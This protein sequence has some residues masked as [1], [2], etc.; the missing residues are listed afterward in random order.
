M[1]PD[2]ARPGRGSQLHAGL[3]R[4]LSV[5]MILIGVALV[6]RLSAQGIVVGLLF[7]VAGVGRLYV[8]ARL[9]RGGG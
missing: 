1:T 8:S 2:S 9:R 5:A 7:V 3:T 6:G 4:I